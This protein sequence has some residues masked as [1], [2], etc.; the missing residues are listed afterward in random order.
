MMDRYVDVRLWLFWEEK[1]DDKTISAR[2]RPTASGKGPY[3][4]VMRFRGNTDILSFHQTVEEAQERKEE[5][6]Y[7]KWMGGGVMHG[8][9]QYDVGLVA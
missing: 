3:A 4:V 2:V 5:L 1:W 6:R 8:G 9:L 7:R